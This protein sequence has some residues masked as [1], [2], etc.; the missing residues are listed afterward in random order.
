MGNQRLDDATL[1]ALHCRA[2]EDGNVHPVDVVRLVAEV[3][4]YKERYDVLDDWKESPVVVAD[5]YTYYD[6]AIRQLIE[7]CGLPRDPGASSP[8]NDGGDTPVV[9]DHKDS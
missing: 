4:W 2:L 9:I 3:R 1:D 6:E 8:K 7:G 5:T